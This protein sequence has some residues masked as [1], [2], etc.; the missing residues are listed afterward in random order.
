MVVTKDFTLKRRKQHC[1]KIL[2]PVNTDTA[3]IA[4]EVRPWNFPEDDPALF[5]IR[6]AITFAADEEEC[7]DDIWSVEEDSEA[8]DRSDIEFQ[9]TSKESDTS[10]TPLFGG[11]HLTLGVSMLLVITFA[12]CHSIIGVALADLL[13]LIEVH[14]ISPNYFAHSMKLLHD[15]FKKLKNP[16]EFHFFCLFEYI[17]AKRH[18]EHCTSKHYLQDFSKKGSLTYFIVVPFTINQ[19]SGLFVCFYWAG[20]ACHF[21]VILFLVWL[22]PDTEIQPRISLLKVE[23][24]MM[25]TRTCRV[26]WAFRCRAVAS[27]RPTE[28]LA[29][30]ISLV[31]AVF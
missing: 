10:G 25:S 13:L 20:W 5:D 9:N 30:V 6:P 18:P 14:L 29:S 11:A 23:Y 19:G 1:M 12:M 4:D 15:F 17:D 8:S 21:Y 24:Q 16:N 31:F 26:N 27:N 28:A 22:Y 3:S 2:K 7:L